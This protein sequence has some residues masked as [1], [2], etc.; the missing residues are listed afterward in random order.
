MPI[1]S[2]DS[3]HSL[4]Q[5]KMYK[6]E[7][8]LQSKESIA[9]KFVFKTDTIDEQIVEFT[10]IDN[11]TG[12]DIICVPCQSM[13]NMSCTFCHLT[14]YVGKVP[15]KNL[16]SFNIIQCIEEVILAINPNM[17]N[18]PKRKLLISFMGAGEPFANIDTL[19]SVMKS[20]SIAKTN[21]RFGMATILPKRYENELIPLIE[22]VE[23][24]KLDLKLHFSL[25]F[26]D[27][28]TRTRWMPSSSDIGSLFTAITNWGNAFGFDK[29]EIHYT[30]MDGVN[31]DVESL[32]KL[33]SKLNKKTT[34]KFMRFSEK[35]SLEAK[36]VKVSEIEALMKLLRKKT[37]VLVEYYEPP[38][39]DIG[40]S[41]GQFLFDLKDKVN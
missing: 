41:C 17:G 1:A 5:A 6:L 28:E 33:A 32:T 30:L 25:H 38:A 18:D 35:E 3:L 8:S 39:Y 7:K 36:Q 15:T 12:K 20:L 34:L 13:C 21:I 31:T 16:V 40:A 2:N 27:D 11:G 10:Y 24:H 19:K 37:G 23:E 4:K 22:F 29:T 26:N 14:D 9:T